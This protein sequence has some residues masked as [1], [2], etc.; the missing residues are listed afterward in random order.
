MIFKTFED[1]SRMK[2]EQLYGPAKSVGPSRNGPLTRNKITGFK[3][4]FQT[5]FLHPY[6]TTTFQ[7]ALDSRLQRYFCGQILVQ[8]FFHAFSRALLMHP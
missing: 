1:P 5:N 4:S 2:T 8:S 6:Y 3:K 7:M